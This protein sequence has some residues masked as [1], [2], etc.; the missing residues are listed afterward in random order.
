MSALL[1][2]G[3]RGLGSRNA[4]FN[5]IEFRRDWSVICSIA[6]CYMNPWWTPVLRTRAMCT[7][8]SGFT[9]EPVR[10]PFRCVARHA[11]SM[12]RD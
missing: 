9:K 3:T 11:F 12:C 7:S 6:K 5:E 4:I 2:L 1:S 8:R 10:W